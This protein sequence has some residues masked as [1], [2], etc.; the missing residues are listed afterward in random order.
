MT[1]STPS[2]P[3]DRPALPDRPS[4]PDRPCL[5]DR[6]ERGFAGFRAPD[7]FDVT[8]P[9]P[10]GTTILEASAGTGKTWTIAALVAR[11]V[12]EGTPLDRMLVVTFGRAASQELREQVRKRLLRVEHFLADPGR[13]PGDRLEA[14]LV[15]DCSQDEIRLRHRRIRDALG[16]FDDATI[17]TIHQFCQLVLRSLG[18]ASDTDSSARLVEDLAT[19]LGEVVDDLYLARFGHQETPPF[20]HG[21]ARALAEAAVAD[22][23]ARIEPAEAPEES[24][25]GIRVAFARAVRSEFDARKRRL[26][27]L[28]YDDLLADLATAL[29]APGSAAGARMRARW[30][31]VLVDEFQDTDPIQWQVFERAFHGH[32]TM[33]LI[34]DPKQA[35]YAFRGGDVDTYLAARRVATTQET[36]GTNRRSDPPLVLALDATLGGM[37]L[38]HPDIVVHP[39]GPHLTT[40]RLAGAPVQE[41][42]RLRVAFAGQFGLGPHDKVRVGDARPALA[43][44]AAAD[45]KRLLLAGATFDGLPLR[46]GHVAVLCSTGAQLALVRNALRDIEVPAVLGADESVFHSPAATEW[47][48]LLEAME[49]PNRSR[50]VRAAAL[51][52][53][54]GRGIDDLDVGGDRVTEETATRLRRWGEL[55]ALR[56][57]PAVL[58]AATVG[59]LASRVLGVVGGERDLTDLRHLAEILH[60]EAL[61]RHHGVTGLTTWLRDQAAAERTRGVTTRSRRLD[62]DA[63][64]VQLATIHGSKGLQYPVVYAPF[65]GDRHIQDVPNPL[66]YHDAR[67]RRCLDLGGA[68]PP[69]ADA[70]ARARAEDDGESLR[71]LYVALTRAQSQV[72]TWW[73]PLTTTPA[74]PL[75]RTLFG[76]RPDGAGQPEP[77]VPLPGP[78]AVRDTLNAWCA[79]GGP[80]PEDAEIPARPPSGRLAA[81]SKVPLGIRSFTRGVD[82]DWRRTSYTALTRVLDTGPTEPDSAAA[83]PEMP[84]RDDESPVAEPVP[85]SSHDPEFHDPRLDAARQVASPMAHLPV[86]ATFGSLVHAVLEEA[87][88]DAPD[89]RSELAARIDE[90][91]LRWPVELSRADLA[92]AL[93]AVCRTPLGPLAPGVSLADIGL[94]NRLCEMEFELPLAGGDSPRIDRSRHRELRLGDLAPLLDTH[95][96]ADDPLRGFADA[97]RLPELGGQ[98]LRGYLTGSVD[99]VL[100][101][102]E[103][104]LVVDYKTNW[105]GP[106]DVPLTAADYR[107]EALVAAMGHSSYPLQALLYAVVLHRFL[108]WRLPGYDPETHL[109]GVLYLYLRG[110]CGPDTPLIDGHPTGVFSWRPP[111]A[112]VRAVS[113]L[114]DGRRGA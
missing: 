99:V 96:P 56:G 70:V 98:P 17:A 48:T 14:A 107:P 63:A 109:G 69:S 50:R 41:P 23:A 74:S 20:T 78:R 29:D 61:A 87:D 65:L 38:G 91:L 32:A 82:L 44:D 102:G 86:G 49:S 51:T 27:V 89:L 108:R 75:H 8:A 101:I 46:P 40:W 45:I 72:V 39:V 19:L 92:D 33:V 90:Q 80:V 26:G 114:L 31:V 93:V 105:L 28:G 25:P 88:P 36:L 42:W 18:V 54:F 1:P 4:C 2:T 81:P 76:R 100:R 110:M 83:E 53:F 67:G 34:G 52:S 24:S 21:A 15:A 111:S 6:P 13:T 66:R 103:R 57:I 60:E 3:S 112:L 5:P 106:T 79:G 11:Y 35:I 59:A 43:A 73:A 7:V 71:L 37:A 104:H 94:R 12:A 95:L 97:L 84:L 30:D 58:E 85:L 62:S 64:A 22:P 68:E 47:L 55:Y 113:D 10:R 9:L 16:A 77:S